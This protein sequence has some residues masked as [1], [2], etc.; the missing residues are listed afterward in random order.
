MEDR[1]SDTLIE[2]LVDIMD[3][4]H[5]PAEPDVLLIPDS[6]DAPESSSVTHADYNPDAETLIVEF[7]GG[8]K[9]GY[10]NIKPAQWV[11]FYQADS[12]GG[13]FNKHIRPLAAGKAL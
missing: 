3:E 2:R 7:K 6:F 1:K 12:K 11:E 13:Y 5:S 8:K 9:Y 4:I 10:G